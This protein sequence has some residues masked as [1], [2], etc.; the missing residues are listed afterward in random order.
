M[1]DTE[2]ILKEAELSPISEEKEENKISWKNVSVGTF[3]FLL[4][5][6][7]TGIFIKFSRN[8]KKKASKI[9]PE[10]ITTIAETEEILKHHLFIGKEYYFR[11]MKRDL[12]NNLPLSF[13]EHYDELHY[14]A[15]EQV[16]LESNKSIVE[17]LEETVN[18]NFAQEFI[19]FRKKIQIEKYTPIHENLEFF[20]ED[21]IKFYSKIMK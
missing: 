21:I 9:L 1:D 17:F 16:A 7:L 3:M 6:I 19:S 18:H 8:R 2:N 13:F 14:D 4:I 12:D 5:I 15:E 20:Y 10:S 11:S